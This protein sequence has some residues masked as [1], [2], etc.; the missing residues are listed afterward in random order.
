[1]GHEPW[2]L[3]WATAIS[4]NKSNGRM[5]I[6]RYAQEFDPRF[7]R[8]EHPDRV[9]IVWKYQT[10]TGQPNSEDHARMNILEDALESALEEDLFATLALVST[11]ENLR[12]WTYYARSADGFVERLNNALKT[13]APYP[14]D[15]HSA[16]DPTWSTYERFK[17][18]L[19][20]GQ[21]RN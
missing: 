9:I 7:D 8:S 19:H 3:K 16:V 12:E 21:G 2:I 5:I 20:E 4:T 13:H 18:D 17:A 11:G 15:I 6:F 14:I 10:E 1:M